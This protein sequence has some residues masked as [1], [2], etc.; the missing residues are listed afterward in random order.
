M[1]RTCKPL[2]VRLGIR[3]LWNKP[4]GELQPALRALEKAVGVRVRLDMDWGLLLKELGHLY[5]DKTH[6]VGV[7]A[8]CVAAWARTMAELAS[9]EENTAWADT[10]ADKAQ[11]ALGIELFVEAAGVRHDGVAWYEL[12]QHFSLILPRSEPIARPDD[13]VAGYRADMLACFDKPS[14]VVA[15]GDDRAD[16]VGKLTVDA[17]TRKPSAATGPSPFLPSMASLPRPDELFL[18]PP[19]HLTVSGG[20]QEIHIDASHSPSLQLLHD[21]LAHWC[22]ANQN[23]TT[24]P[25]AIQ[26]TLQRSAFGAALTYDRLVLSTKDT[27][28]ASDSFHV[29]VPAVAAF[30]EGVLGYERVAVSASAAWVFRRDAEIKQKTVAR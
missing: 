25:P 12:P 26:I 7:V 2:K 1:T 17:G 3:E 14:A 13:L 24:H 30:V 6:F 19:Y 5:P 11:A 8:G 21:Y 27:R 16:E 29:S 4:D 15:A 18:R 22:R 28:Y 10:L 23:D 20:P 9:D